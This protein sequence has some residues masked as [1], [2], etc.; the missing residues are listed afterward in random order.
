MC[1]LLKNICQGDDG[2]SEWCGHRG[3]FWA[4]LGVE[5]GSINVFFI[6][7][8][9]RC[10]KYWWQN[11]TKQSSNPLLFSHIKDLESKVGQLKEVTRSQHRSAGLATR[12]WWDS[13]SKVWFMKGAEKFSACFFGSWLLWWIKMVDWLIA[14]SLVVK[15][16]H[17]SPIAS[18]K[19]QATLGGC[20]VQQ[21]FLKSKDLELSNC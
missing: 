19:N 16:Q 21:A 14:S 18:N 7:C 17:S 3:T 10:K 5:L 2:T 6:K 1:K 15:H 13:T 12:W 20:L 4:F 11:P 8:N 9:I